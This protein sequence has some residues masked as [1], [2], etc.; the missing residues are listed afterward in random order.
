MIDETI[1]R[2]LNEWN[3]PTPVNLTPQDLFYVRITQIQDFFRILVKRTEET[4][5]KEFVSE[6]ISNILISVNSILINVL[7]KIYEFRESKS[8]LISINDEKQHRYEY[9]PWTSTS[10]KNGL[11]DIILTMIPLTLKYGARDMGEPEIRQQHYY[12]LF[13]LI[14]FYLNERRNYLESIMDH[15]KYRVLLHQ[16]ESKRSELIMYLLDDEQFELSAK[17][18]EKYNDFQCLITLC[19]RTNNQKRFEEYIARYKDNDFSQFAIQWHIKKNKKGELFEKFKQNQAELSKFLND[20]PNLAWIQCVFNGELEMASKILYQ[21][22]ISEVDLVAR[23][24]TM[25]SLSKLSALASKS[26]SDLVGIIEDINSQ[27][28]LI[29]H[30]EQLPIGILTT[31]GYDI[32][33]LKVLNAEQII[34]VSK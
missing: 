24:K 25:L 9:L 7:K 27:L 20:H 14:D 19:D 26:E 33:N 1:E 29:N 31:F 11:K 5:Q 16:Y 18:A 12:H 22:A 23:K 8:S 34:N 2:V 10:G 32:D 17:L 28:L 13:E 3:H 15:E 30:Q 4:I 6:N 21:L